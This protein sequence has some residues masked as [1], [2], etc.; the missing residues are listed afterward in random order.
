LS[1]PDSSGGAA[2]LIQTAHLGDVV[3][4]L[5]L[6]QRLAERHGPVDVLTIPE[7]R[8]LVETHPAVR[9]ALSFDKHRTDRGLSGLLRTARALR[10]GRYACAYLPHESLR[11]A[12]LTRLAG[13]GTIT[14]FAG[15]PGAFL[16]SRRITRP[17]TGPM[18][19]RLATLAERGGAP[20]GRWL[21]LT[22]A[23]RRRAD[24]WLTEHGVGLGYV[25]LAPGARWGSKRWPYFG[26]LAERLDLE[27][28]V[29]GGPAEA[30][31]GAAIA[32]RAPGRIRSAA[33]AL[34]LR[35]SAAIIER[36]DLLVANDSVAI[37][38]AGAL[39]R[40]AIAIFG[41]TA[42]A[43]GFGPRGAADTVIE[44]SGLTCRPCSVH[45]PRSCPL[46]HHR[47]LRELPVERV[48]SAVQARPRPAP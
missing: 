6:I 41:P 42:P 20:A 1:A 45:G 19:E 4:T 39:Q 23:D 8:P 9:Q 21:A 18:S 5:P 2:L 16:Y 14:G 30:A 7:A 47:C 27:V 35:E 48:L 11:S 34:S 44:L 40:P 37:H 15:A 25:V 43:F 29:I 32:A 31:E 28:V 13:I 22:E 38:L 26:D 36:A 24:Q 17:R 12:V 33:G 3:L 10:A 46:G